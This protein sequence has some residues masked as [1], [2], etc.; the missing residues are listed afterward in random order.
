M[1]TKAGPGKDAPS[2]I[3]TSKEFGPRPGRPCVGVIE[4]VGSYMGVIEMVG[5]YIGVIE[6]VGPTTV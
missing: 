5:P 2:Y 4:I 3:A 6:M 1:Y